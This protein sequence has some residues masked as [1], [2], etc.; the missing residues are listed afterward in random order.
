MEHSQSPNDGISGSDLNDPN[1]AQT[2]ARGVS[3]RIESGVNREAASSIKSEQSSAV[4]VEAAA[5]AEPEKHK[6]EGTPKILLV[7]FSALVVVAIIR[8]VVPWM[9]EEVQYASARGRQRA[10]FELASEQLQNMSSLTDLSKSYELIM[11]RVGPSV[12]HINTSE[13]RVVRSHDFRRLHGDIPDDLQ[14]LGSGVIIDPNGYI[15]TNF[16]VIQGA[17]IID[18]T[19]ADERMFQAE[20]IGADPQ[21]DLALLKIEASDLIVAEWGESDELR[22]GS[23]VWAI[24]SPYGLSRSITSGIVSGKNRSRLAGN[25]SQDLLQTDVA[26]NPGNSGGPLV[27]TKGNV[28]GINTAIYGDRFNGISFAIPSNIAKEMAGRMRDGTSLSKEGY[29]GIAMLPVDEKSA[30]RLGF[31]GTHGVLVGVVRDPSPAQDAGL[32]VDDILLRWDSVAVSSPEQLRALVSQ[33]AIGS[34][35]DADYYRAGAIKTATVT[36]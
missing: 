19:L 3:Y 36:V 13:Q 30:K 22:E 15:L 2:P 27:N 29:L 34:K 14:G 26:L 4:V 21:T 7:T 16:H 24:G 31:D 8:F 1:R 9:V 28:V 32:Q 10:E 35:V 25:P 33:T 12:V 5:V 6:P 20:V 17:E 11:Q 23:L 18:V